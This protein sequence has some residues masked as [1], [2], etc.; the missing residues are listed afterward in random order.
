GWL[1]ALRLA[2]ARAELALAR[3]AFDAAI[4]LADASLLQ[5]RGR[6][7]KYEV[8]ALA[9]RASA[10]VGL[11][12]ASGAVMDL[13]AAVRVARAV[14][15]PALFV[16]SASALLAIDGDDTLAAE[17]RVTA[18]HMLSRMPTEE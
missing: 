9:T 8:L 7:P 17:T 16:R 15:D 12:R 1:W 13:R 11:G 5:A 2:Q 18:E 3:G 10:L 4:T 14:A 6:R